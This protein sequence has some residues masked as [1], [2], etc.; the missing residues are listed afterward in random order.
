MPLKNGEENSITH[1]RLLVDSVTLRRQKDKIDLPPRTDL[2]VRLDFSP[3][4]KEIYDA[5]AKQSS[6][7]VDK[8]V[9]EG[10]MGGKGY[11][12]VLQMILRLRRIC[13]HGRE[14]LGDADAIEIAGLTSSDAINVD[15]IDETASNL[16]PNTAYEIFSLMKETNEDVCA[17]CE[18]KAIYKDPL[19]TMDD[20]MTAGGDKGKEIEG[21]G[22]DRTKAAMTLGFLT[23][24]AHMLCKDCVSSYTFRISEDF[25]DGMRAACPICSLHNKIHLFELK[26]DELNKYLTGADTGKL[27]KKKG[28]HY[29]GPSTKVK[30]LLQ[31]L[32]QNRD[33]GS[34][35]GPIKSVVFSCW[36]QHMDLIE[37][38]FEDNGI[39][40]VRLDGTMSRT[41]R[42]AAIAK[43]RDD[44]T[45]EVILVSL[46]AGGLG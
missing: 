24:C 25:E 23:T 17:L 14:L 11:V 15:E 21:E 41:Q 35:D 1:L 12:H 26:Y 8:V 19:I 2:I 28:F 34:K 4:E 31:A 3:E 7:R 27:T 5:T 46:M 13:A 38:A 39:I 20:Q 40:S 6:E 29:K 42:N 36:T 43:F 10:H 16:P 44:P 22:K 33:D 18:K 9:K 45:V 30:A 32:F 37:C